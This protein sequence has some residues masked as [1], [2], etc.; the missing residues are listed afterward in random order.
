MPSH[1]ETENY[2]SYKDG[3]IMIALMAT[4]I[5]G[6]PYWQFQGDIGPQQPVWRI[7]N[8]DIPLITNEWFKV[9]YYLKWSDK[10]LKQSFSKHL[11]K[12]LIISY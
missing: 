9:E 1:L 11:L 4:D 8:Y 7:E 6:T 3:F 12:C 2:A 10:N 5:R